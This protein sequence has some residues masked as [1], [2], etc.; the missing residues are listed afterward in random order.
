MGMYEADGV[1]E[2][3]KKKL[4]VGFFV[5]AVFFFIVSTPVFTSRTVGEGTG[6]FSLSLSLLHALTLSPSFEP[7]TFLLGRKM[8]VSR[9]GQC[10]Q[11]RRAAGR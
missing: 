9:S 10:P 8:H 1:S 2:T 11:R 3:N 7:P 5:D 6:Y 4:S